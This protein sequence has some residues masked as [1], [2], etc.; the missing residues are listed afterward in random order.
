MN[1]SNSVAL[2]FENPFMLEQRVFPSENMNKTNKEIFW[3]KVAHCQKS[4]THIPLQQKN[5]T[6][7][8]KIGA[9]SKAQ[10]AQKT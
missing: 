6:G 7:T 2:K 10:K 8:S 5:K 1:F 3:K 4:Q 9:I